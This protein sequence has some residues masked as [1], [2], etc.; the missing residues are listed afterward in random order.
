MKR[1]IVLLMLGVAVGIAPG[2][3]SS[4]EK[5]KGPVCESDADCEEPAPKCAGGECVECTNDNDCSSQLVCTGDLSGE[6]GDQLSYT[7]MPC[8]TDSDCGEDQSCDTSSSFYQ[9]IP[10]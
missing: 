10:K 4:G 9:C 2:C 1:S 7:C 5:D 8:M 6:D 3:G